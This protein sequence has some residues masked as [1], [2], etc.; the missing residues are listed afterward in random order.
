MIG[1][2]ALTTRRQLVVRLALILVAG[3]QAVTNAAG[4]SSELTWK[5]G[6]NLTGH[7]LDASDTHL[8]WQS[9]HFP[10]Q[11][12]LQLPY[13]SSIAFPEAD[14]SGPAGP[15]RFRTQSGDVVYGELIDVT[16]DL[17]VVI[18]SPRHGEFKIP[19]AALRSFR[20]FD[21]PAMAYFGP[22]GTTGWK[23]LSVARFTSDWKRNANDEIVTSVYA[24][25]LFR[26]LKLG[27]LAEIDISLRWGRR[28]GFLITFV[29][30]DALRLSQDAVR[31]ETRGTELIL[32]TL[33]P[34][35]NAQ[36]IADL[37]KPT[38]SIELR[39]IWN[40]LSGQLA[41]YSMSGKILGKIEAGPA[42]SRGHS[43]LFIRNRG[44]DLTIA[45]LRV[46]DEG[47]R[48]AVR[49]TGGEII[50]GE[51]LAFDKENRM[52]AVQEESGATRQ[53]PLDEVAVGYLGDAPA[54]R[55]VESG[56]QLGYFDG[57]LIRG[58][59]E[60]IRAGQIRVQTA[61]CAEPLS[62][63]LAGAQELMFL[64]PSPQPQYLASLEIPGARLHGRLAPAGPSG[65]ELG[66]ETLGSSNSI[67]I[68]QNRP[69]RFIQDLMERARHSRGPLPKDVVYLTNGDVVR[70][71][72]DK[73]DESSLIGST[74]FSDN[75]QLPLSSI[76]AIDFNSS[77]QRSS[78]SRV[79]RRVNKSALNAFLT[80]PRLRREHPPTHA[81]AAKNGDWLRGRL[82]RL[83][84]E[85]VRFELPLEEIEIPRTR[86]ASIV[87]LQTKPE[88]SAEVTNDAAIARAEL[89]DGSQ[90]TFI[91][92]G[93]SES[94][95][96]L[97]HT[98][99]GQRRLPLHT[100][101]E[102]KLGQSRLDRAANTYSEW[103]LQ[104]AK[105]P[106]FVAAANE[107]KSAGTV[108]IGKRSPLV[109]SKAC[110]VV[111]PLLDGTTFK[112]RDY[113]DT[114]VVLDFWATWSAQ[115]VGTLPETAA[116]VHE[117]P[118]DDVVLI[119][120]N[121]QQEPA[122]IRNFLKLRQ[123]DVIVAL[124]PES[125]IASQ[126]DVKTIPQTVIIG[127]DGVIERLYVGD[128]PDLQQLIKEALEGLIDR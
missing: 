118:S 13:L 67:P 72:V 94:E 100:V 110:P 52:L 86:L 106:L 114:V 18:H 60:S 42:G 56:I 10:R 46:N 127:R 32:Q 117:F 75:T 55:P 113:G 84:G 30:P 61:Y 71:Q 90:L 92:E 115:S 116:T 35:G 103:T 34:N 121:Q 124:D 4:E 122:N 48:S 79:P 77:P 31:L 95:I 7:L 101:R 24:A 111:A 45:H 93:L 119:A 29:D 17:E 20:R 62:A 70:C 1:R 89:V 12:E 37:S 80:L 49:L 112:L 58:K 87:W 11:L 108:G 43:G 44:S 22:T 8:R 38:N 97:T 3:W 64:T 66:W 36:V 2:S 76:K 107:A 25:E 68:P 57:T 105:D 14:V 26:D 23:T 91:P 82:I 102:I 74:I 21:D 128:V 78:G 27:D 123:L 54:E 9:P 109:G 126:F 40:Q 85:A 99:L 41:V 104:Q 19:L 47:G 63:S 33:S 98:T 15:L 16:T 88:E 59:L 51:I 50:Y 96:Q 125:E 39:L 69:A 83:S 65:A 53:F 120:V 73:I 5:S 81:L 6:G 28:P